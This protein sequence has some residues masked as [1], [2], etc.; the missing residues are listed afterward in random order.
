MI[1]TQTITLYVS[2]TPTF[3]FFLGIVYSVAGEAAAVVSLAE[4]ISTACSLE[5]AGT[6]TLGI[7]VLWTAKDALTRG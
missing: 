1:T 2:V 3:L 6:H 5:G 7:L 4:S